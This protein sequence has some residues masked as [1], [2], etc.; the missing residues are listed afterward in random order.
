MATVSHYFDA[1]SLV[2]PAS[3]GAQLDLITG[4]NFPIPVLAFD[5]A[6]EENAYTRA[7]VANNYGSGNWTVTFFWEADTATSGDVIFG[8]ALAAVTANTDSGGYESKAFATAQTVTD[9]HLGT[10]ADRLMSA[11]LTLSNLD[12]VAS[13]DVC[14]LRVYRDADAGGDTMAGDAFLVGVLVE[15][16]DT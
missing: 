6:T 11:G 7:F 5:A 4:T 14:V 10:N 12:S 3:A 15:Y 1:F 16:S 13:G 9:T 2:P 8:A